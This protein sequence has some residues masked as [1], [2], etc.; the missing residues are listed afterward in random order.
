MRTMK[1]GT[2]RGGAGDVVVR[3]EEKKRENGKN[4]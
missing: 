2:G 1:R 3:K 4:I